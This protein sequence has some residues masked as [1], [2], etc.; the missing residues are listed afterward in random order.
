M[1]MLL[2]FMITL[3]FV[4][5]GVGLYILYSNNL[6][7]N[8]EPTIFVDMDGVLCDFE[9]QFYTHFLQTP[10]QYIESK[11]K[12]AFY[13]DVDNIPNFW[14]SIPWTDYGRDLW[15]S[16]L[17][18]SNKLVI[19][20]DPGEFGSSRIG[21]TTWVYHNLGEQNLVLHKEKHK[22]AA[23]GRILLDDLPH[24]IEAFRTAGGT[25]YRVCNTASAKECIN[26]IRRPK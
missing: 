13:Q 1:D 2:F 8:P 7:P 20:S 9:G 4:F 11:G 16:L 21:K 18:T 17:K 15:K 14:E 5:S 3:F 22:W 23:P 19:L 24:N 10:R 25:A 26:R 12:E 6:L